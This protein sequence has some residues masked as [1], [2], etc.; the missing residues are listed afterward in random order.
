MN[1]PGRERISRRTVLSGVGLAAT[2]IVTG[3]IVYQAVK[4]PEP[5][6]VE[7]LTFDR[8]KGERGSRYH[9]A[10]RGSGDVY[11]EHS[12]EAYRAAARW[13]AECME[14]SIG[15]TSDGVLICMHDSTY[16]RTTT[17]TGPVKDQP[18]SVLSDIRILQPQLGEGWVRNAPRVPLLSE[19][20]TT[21]GGFVVLAL[22]AKDDSAYPAMMAMV[23]ERG[24]TESVI[25]KMHY[26]SG[27]LAEAHAAGYPVFS[28]FGSAR[29]TTVEEVVAMGR[30]LD[31]GRDCLVVPGF[32]SSGGPYVE[33]K[34]V[35]AAVKTGV[36][37]W[38][39][40]LHRR[41]D[42][43]H[44][45]DLGA[46]G[47]ICSSFG[48]ISSSSASVNRDG[49]E[50][51]LIASGEISRAPDRARYAPV[52]TPEGALVLS[53]EGQQHFITL[54]QFSPL[55]NAEASYRIEVEVSWQT[56]PKIDNDNISVAFGR[57]DDSYYEHRQGLGTGY[58]AVLRANGELGLYLHQDGEES[59]VVLAKAVKTPKPI[60]GGW[61]Q[62]R[63]EVT[64]AEI[65]VTRLDVGAKVSAADRTIRGGYLHVGR[66]ST[67]GVAAFRGLTVA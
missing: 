43:K 51:Q 56:L 23:E 47:A 35:T 6:E 46:Q 7:S 62:L 5:P 50:D 26:S 55:K 19:V 37:V 31:A 9:I 8:W 25:V 36:P 20:L 22:E 10:H 18:S 54:G 49:W 32:T 1:G 41:S 40:P 28:Y 59:G 3:A 21:F 12:M 34:L 60:P 58:H 11:P 45:F 17:G 16:D 24:L 39:H 29:E 42:A 64:P 44:F 30:R 13:G 65:S 48:Y 33:D 38:V 14:I 61:V 27:R 4:P 53:A 2:G 57:A 63:I 66:S 15:I 52:F 67:D